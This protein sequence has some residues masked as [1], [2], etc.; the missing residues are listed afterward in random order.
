MEW[1]ILKEGMSSLLE[2]GLV[3]LCKSSKTTLTAENEFVSVESL[4]FR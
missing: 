3:L 1:S 2:L 4:P